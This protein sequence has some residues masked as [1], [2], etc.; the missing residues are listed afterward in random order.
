MIAP[1][2]D[3]AKGSGGASTAFETFAAY[4]QLLPSE[5]FFQLQSGV[6]LPV[7][8]DKIS[9]AYY[10]RT[11]LGKSFS[12]GGGFG[13]R[14]T[15]MT[16]FIADRDIAT[17]ARTNWDILPELQIPLSKRMHILG[18]I[19]IRIPVN[20]TRERPRQLMFYL[21]WDWVDGGLTEG[22]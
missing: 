9:R 21:L 5:S 16:E 19:G 10:L 11:A 1:T 7:H 12:A 2:G 13:R 20:H 15:P 18:N 3:P 17:G 14:W 22:W 8:P 6:E 4:G